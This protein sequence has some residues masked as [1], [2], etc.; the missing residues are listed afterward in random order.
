MK[1]RPRATAGR[2]AAFVACLWCGRG[3]ALTEASGGLKFPDGSV[4]TTALGVRTVSTIT[5][6]V[7]AQVGTT[8]LCNAG[9]SLVITLPAS[10]APGDQ[11]QVLGVSSGGWRVVANSGQRLIDSSGTTGAIGGFLQSSTGTDAIGLTCVQANMLWLVTSESNR[12]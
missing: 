8:Y 12:H 3:L 1:P 4:Q 2:I 9:I 10:C 5:S 7:A 6:D 11:V